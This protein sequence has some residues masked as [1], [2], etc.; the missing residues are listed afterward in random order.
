MKYFTPE[1][2]QQ[3]NSFDVAEAERADEAWDQAE[4][5]YKERLAS[6]RE[7]LTSAVI[8]L[9]ELC[10]HDALVVSRPPAEAQP[11]GPSYYFDKTNPLPPPFLWTAVQIVSVQLGE[12][13]ISLIYGIT[14][15]P[16]PGQVPAGWRF[17]P[18]QEQWLYDEVDIL[19]DRKGPFV[20][21]ILFSTG[22][23]LEIPFATVI[24]HK[25]TLPA[26]AKVAK[27][28]A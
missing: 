28:S 7:L 17:S 27:Q 3:F 23:T 6:I 19:N 18:Q 8:K 25:F 4:A 2:Y 10:L 14:D 26:V 11:A 21:R 5:A 24:I 20:H 16:V 13:I 22:I 12:E 15:E 9:S 1:L